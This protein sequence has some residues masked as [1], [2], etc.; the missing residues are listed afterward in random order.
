MSQTREHH[1]A[2]VENKQVHSD[3]EH[4]IGR[5]GR[6]VVRYTE[7]VHHPANGEVH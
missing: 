3:T 7:G 1:A 5:H 6:R 4:D 2:A